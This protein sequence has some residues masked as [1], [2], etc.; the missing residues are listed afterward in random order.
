MA[1]CVVLRRSSTIN[2]HCLQRHFCGD[3]HRCA[4]LKQL[5][6]SALFIGDDV[7]LG[8]GGALDVDAADVDT[9]D[10]P[11]GHYQRSAL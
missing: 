6:P 8:T 11:A 3:C 2:L 1:R 7:G 5:F 10:V 9:A 4:N